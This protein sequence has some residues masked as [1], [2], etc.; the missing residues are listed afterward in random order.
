M[1]SVMSIVG[2]TEDIAKLLSITSVDKDSLRNLLSSSMDCGLLTSPSVDKHSLCN[3]LVDHG[4]LD[5]DSLGNLGIPSTNYGL[6][7]PQ[8]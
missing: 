3:L 5:K 6:L 8:S 1:P 2:N 7:M 4:L